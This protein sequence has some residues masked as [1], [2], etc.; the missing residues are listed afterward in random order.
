MLLVPAQAALLILPE[1]D[2]LSVKSVLFVD[3]V[4]LSTS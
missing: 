2:G 3:V 1:K 4:Q